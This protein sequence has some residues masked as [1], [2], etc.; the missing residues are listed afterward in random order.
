L[1]ILMGTA[2]Y[3]IKLSDSNAKA[4]DNALTLYVIQLTV[5]FLWPIF[6]FKLGLYLFSFIWLLL[7]L[8]LIIATAV[9][10]YKISKPAAYLMLPYIAWVMFAGYL[11][12]GIYLLN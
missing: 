6:F 2:S 8:V 11:N 9:A 1:F 12:L 4:V 3:L 7:L 5:N 10:F